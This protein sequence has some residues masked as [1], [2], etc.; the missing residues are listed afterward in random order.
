MIFFDGN[1]DPLAMHHA[2]F[3]TTGAGPISCE[4][5]SVPLTRII[6]AH[7]SFFPDVAVSENNDNLCIRR[8]TLQRRTSRLVPQIDASF[9]AKH[10]PVIKKKPGVLRLAQIPQ[11]GPDRERQG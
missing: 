8:T 5:Y 9:L 3:E 10:K 7:Q 2:G 1:G 6:K 4:R 11:Y